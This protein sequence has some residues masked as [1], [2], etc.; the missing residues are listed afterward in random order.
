MTIL[1][2]IYRHF[3]KVDSAVS[4]FTSLVNEKALAYYIIVKLVF[5]GGTATV[6]G[7]TI[8]N[9]S[10]IALIIVSLV[11]IA[12]CL[13]YLS[14]II[15]SDGIQVQ[16][17]PAEVD[18]AVKFASDLMELQ[19]GNIQSSDIYNYEYVTN[20]EA[21]I[22]KGEEIWIVS[23]DLEEDTQNGELEQLIAENLKNGV[24]YKYFI[25][26]ENG[27]VSNK[28]NLGKAKL[29]NQNEAYLKRLS[30][31]E[32]DQE[33]FAPDIDIIIYNAS[34]VD[35]RI[36]FACV[37]IGDDSQTYIYQKIDE[38]ILQGIYDSLSRNIK[39]KRNFRIG[40][41]IKNLAQKGLLFCVKNLSIPYAV[42]SYG[43]LAIMSFN[44]IMTIRN[45]IMFVAPAIGETF[46]TFLLAVIFSDLISNYKNILYKSG[47]DEKMLASIFNSQEI[48]YVTEQMKGQK[49][50]E[51]KKSKK[52]G[53]AKEILRIDKRCKCI[54][55]L[56]D[57]SHDI[58]N[59]VFCDWLMEEMEK[60]KRLN[61]KFIHTEDP[62]AV[63]RTSDLKEI[64]EAYAPRITDKALGDSS[65]HFIWSE[66]YGIVFAQ[67]HGKS[68]DVY[69]SIGNGNDTFYKC[70]LLNENE[71]ATLLG[72]FKLLMN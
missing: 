54:W 70:V 71:S 44:K 24:R 19:R 67:N 6:L 52:L 18:S 42:I 20:I 28:A 41:I 38:R 13:G 5:G 29:Q 1:R 39:N 48:K 62:A 7:D 72:R 66:T 9:N 26:K 63:G 25:T 68:H 60:N 30:F 46:I 56:S 43:I 12:M 33:L 64:Q 50:E 11:D 58:S 14:T 32:I 47:S 49:L 61:C 27:K 3:I 55:I 22:S 45:L 35:T 8:I 31:E 53:N 36:G 51:I 37:E 59:E 21:N 65:A 69:I 15:K 10:F 40:Q 34:N 2:K 17:I 23:G 57:L 16:E 4:F